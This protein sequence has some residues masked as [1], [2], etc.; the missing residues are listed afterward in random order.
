MKPFK[1]Y[2]LTLLL[3]LVFTYSKAQ[4]IHNR[5]FGTS[6]SDGA[7]DIV[8]D[9]NRNYVMLGN[10]YKNLYLV[11]ADTNA[12]LIWEKSY[13]VDSILLYPSSICEIGDT[14]YVVAG[15]YQNI[16]FL[17]KVTINGDTLFH[18]LDSSILGE[19]VSNLR[20]APDGNLLA[21]V[22][23]NGN[24]MFNLV[25]FDN[26]LNL[27]TSINNIVPTVKGI[28]VVNNNVYLLKEDSLDNLLMVNNDL[29]PID[30]TTIPLYPFYLNDYLRMSFDKTQLIIDGHFTNHVLSPRKRFY[31]DLSGNIEKT[32]DTLGLY[33][34]EFQTINSNNDI[35]HAGIRYDATWGPDIR[36]YFV[37]DGCENSLKDTIL[38]RGGSFGN[39]WAEEKLVKMLV[40]Q[41]G[42]YVLFGRAEQGP[43]GDWDLF[44]W[45]YKKWDGFITAMEDVE[46]QLSFF[47]N[48]PIVYP[49]PTQNQFTISGISENSTISVID[50][51]GKMVYTTQYS[52]SHS[53]QAISTINWAKGL[54]LVQIKGN[55][56]TTSLKVVKQ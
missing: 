50:V 43:I 20:Q 49:N 51:M 52:T 23:F 5:A 15:K 40:D 45:I 18:L 32:C 28:E 25:K 55:K 17:L 42:N 21:L 27:I 6:N 10:H 35:V 39:P 41:N 33:F 31:T 14:S 46:N 44:L 54:Y 12:Q 11:K 53:H 29:S 38:Y 4:V 26:S 7:H 30:T 16:G 34:T 2:I 9:H 56:A 48:T 19:N 37:N 24:S 1:N 47:K 36:L 8:I 13:P 3:L 22:S